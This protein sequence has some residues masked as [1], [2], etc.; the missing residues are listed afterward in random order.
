MISIKGI[1]KHYISVEGL[2]NL[3]ETKE[4]LNAV[5]DEL[6]QLL[7]DNFISAYLVRVLYD[8]ETILDEGLEPEEILLFSEGRLPVVFVNIAYRLETQNSKQL[9]QLEEK[10][11][12]Q[13]FK[14]FSIGRRV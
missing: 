10:F 3:N 9:K 14:S 2:D 5:G 8:E 1:G 4:I 6:E 13:V 7:K 12:L 11:K